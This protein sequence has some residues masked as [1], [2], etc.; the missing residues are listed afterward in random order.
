MGTGRLSGGGLIRP[1]SGGV[2]WELDPPCAA[3]RSIGRGAGISLLLRRERHAQRG[4]ATSTRNVS[5][6]AELVKDGLQ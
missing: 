4:T 6:N 2:S 5:V 3:G 1:V